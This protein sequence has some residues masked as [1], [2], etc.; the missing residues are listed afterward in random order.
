MR[1]AVC[2]LRHHAFEAKEF[3]KD[4]N[5]ELKYFIEIVPEDKEHKI[6]HRVEQLI[7]NND[8][9]GVLFVLYSS[10]TR[11]DSSIKFCKAHAFPH[12]GILDLISAKYLYN[13]RD[14]VYWLDSAKDGYITYLE[15]NII[16]SCNLNCK[17]C[18]HFA[19]L[20][21]D[22]D[23]YDAETFESDVKAISEKFDV[24]RF[25]LLGGEPFK[26]DNLL[27][28]VRVAKKY[29]PKTHV[30]LVTN[31]LL[32]STTPPPAFGRDSQLQCCC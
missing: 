22:D 17:G 27:D 3:L 23:F 28:Y 6:L 5:Y 10:T 32:I 18:S 16:D 8:I 26:K 30:H 19:S 24:I 14:A 1:L 31:G 20:F 7:H 9:D 2:G 12:I 11:L 4:T 21:T 13:P 25:R 29:F 15:T